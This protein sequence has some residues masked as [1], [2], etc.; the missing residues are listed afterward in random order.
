ME[1]GHWSVWGVLIRNPPVEIPWLSALLRVIAIGEVP[2]LDENTFC[3]C[4]ILFI[5]LKIR[6]CRQDVMTPAQE[7]GHNPEASTNSTYRRYPY[8]FPAEEILEST[9]TCFPPAERV[10]ESTLTCCASGNPWWQPGNGPWDSMKVCPRSIL[11]SRF[12]VTNEPIRTRDC[13]IARV[14]WQSRSRRTSH[15]KNVNR[16]SFVRGYDPPPPSAIA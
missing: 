11:G 3:E 2:R 8:F 13:V 9:S 5:N 10:P 15:Q 14:K 12:E 7:G 16:L 1:S 4:D 6:A